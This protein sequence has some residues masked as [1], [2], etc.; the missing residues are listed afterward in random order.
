MEAKD[1]KPL[2]TQNEVENPVEK[3]E[4]ENVEN[5]EQTQNEQVDQVENEA[6]V[7]E[8]K[9]EEVDVV[10]EVS[11]EVV[12]EK[13]AEV[14]ITAVEETNSTEEPTT[15]E[16]DKAETTETIEEPVEKEEVIDYSQHTQIELINALREVLKLDRL[17]KIQIH[18]DQIKV[19]FYKKN[20]ALVEVQK[21]AFLEAGGVEEEFKPEQNP[22]EA[23]LKNLLNEFRQMRTAQSKEMEA[24]KERNL[25]RKYEIIE[26]IKSLVNRKESI[27]KTFQEFRELQQSWREVGLIPQASMK[28]LWET[29]H[30][31]VENF[32]DYIKINKELRDLD[33]KKNQEEKLA[34]CEKAE[35]LMLEPSVIKAFNALQKLHES[36]RETGPVPR[37]KKDEIWERFK[38]ATT[39]INKKHQEFFENRKIAQKKNLEAKTALCEKVEEIL[40][41][42]LNSHKE[43]E[44]KSK[45]LVEVQKYWR[46]IG[47]TPKKENN[48]IYDRFRTACDQFF[49]QKRAF[50]ARHKEEQTNNL[51][52]KIDLCVQAEALKDS[53]DWKK[54][55]DEFISIQKKWKEI[56]PVPRKHSDSVW[57]RFRAACDFF[58]EKKSNFFNTKD[59]T[60]IENLKLKNELIDEVDKFEMEGADVDDFNKLRDFQR[61]W[62]EIGHVPMSDKN[63]VQKRFRDIINAKFD[64]LRLEDKERNL[65]KFKHKMSDW[66]DSGRGHNK[67]YAERDKYVSKLKQ[68]EN[69]L[70]IL[71]NN[72][73]FF[74]NSKNA[75]S[76]IKDVKQKIK[77]NVEQVAYLKEKIRVIDDVEYNEE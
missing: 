31:H 56:G 47:F 53:T 18:A 73:G 54:T 9:K 52:M 34:L 15:E 29:Y 32:Y 46:T 75:E 26:E 38:D 3:T 11:D 30:H 17:S 33:L 48:V 49:D 23:D 36:W 61:R 74:S 7:V 63:S 59:E 64:K 25:Q 28:G 5:V 10:E 4:L 51:Q 67:M 71:Q 62:T 2:E 27:N 35:A 69:D 41:L 60:Q 43:W 65:L 58:F 72:I 55:T 14:E 39:V 76:L 70:I 77:N 22:Y 6:P 37:E 45:E 16:S 44:D 40:T 1:N 20:K 13:T 50:Y 21:K 66:K 57:K 8:E 12:E 24:E 42:E 19:N 68:L